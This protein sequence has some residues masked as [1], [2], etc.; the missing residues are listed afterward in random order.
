MLSRSRSL[1]RRV[2]SKAGLEISATTRSGSASGREVPGSRAEKAKQK[3]ADGVRRVRP[4]ALV[5]SFASYLQE[6][7]KL[8]LLFPEGERALAKEIY[9]CR[10]QALRTLFRSPAT[11]W[12]ILQ[13]NA[14]IRKGELD[15]SDLV[16]P[17]QVPPLAAEM[18]GWRAQTILRFSTLAFRA[19]E[20][21][22]ASIDG[23]GEV[24]EGRNPGKDAEAGFEK[25]I[26]N[27]D[28]RPEAV[29]RLVRCSN[30]LIRRIREVEAGPSGRGF[31]MELES[32]LGMSPDELKRIGLRIRENLLRER[33]ARKELVEANLRLVVS[34]AKKYQHRGLSFAD[35]VQEGNIG[36]MRAAE[37]FDYQRGNR[38]S[39]FATWWIR[40]AIGRALDNQ[41]RTVRL[42]VHVAQQMSRVAR[43]GRRL[44]QKSSGPAPTFQE[45]S[46]QSGVPAEKIAEILELG[47]GTIS[48]D[49]PVG[50]DQQ[51]RLLDLVIDRGSISPEGFALR[52]RLFDEAARVISRLNSREKKVVSLRSG[53][54]DGVERSLK[55]V[56]THLSVSVPRVRQIE[57]QAFRKLRQNRFGHRIP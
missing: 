37:R 49:A 36:L 2:R 11:A 41:A 25:Q 33:L 35:L 53:L 22:K 24:G 27:M 54:L 6:L 55:E 40:Q 26:R 51:E 12:Q 34:V 14:E 19:R 1:E 43:L 44:K 3:E 21:L 23:T 45:L 57:A 50:Q 31:L 42:P 46:D 4:R 38:F 39:T 47:R 30:D 16:V 18:R 20:L 56:G 5:D 7:R 9:S 28:F 15:P 32:D 52:N 17:R 13:W 10:E 8:P 29:D 48:L